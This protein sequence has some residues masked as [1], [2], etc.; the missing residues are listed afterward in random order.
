[1]ARCILLFLLASLVCIA[2][3]HVVDISLD[4]FQGVS[5]RDFFVFKIPLR[6]YISDANL[7][8]LEV[9]DSFRT[10]W[11]AE[12]EGSYCKYVWVYWSPDRQALVELLVVDAESKMERISYK[13]ERF[14][15][16]RIDNHAFNAAFYRTKSEF[17]LMERSIMSSGKASEEGIR[18]SVGSA[19]STPGPD[20]HN[21]NESKAVVDGEGG[22]KNV[23]DPASGQIVEFVRPE[24][25]PKFFAIDFDETFYIHDKEAF[26]KN[27]K[28]F[29]KVR[30]MGYI[31]FI[32]TARPFETVMR[33]LGEDFVTKTGY[34]GYPG[35]YLS[36]SVV[37]DVDGSVLHVSKFSREFLAAF[38]D[39]IEKEDL[40]DQCIFYD[41]RKNYALV[42]PKE[43]V[44][45]VLVIDD[46]PYPK[47]ATPEEILEME[48]ISIVTTNA[49]MDIPMV[50][51]GIDFSSRCMGSNYLAEICPITITKVDALKILMERHGERA[52]A[53]GFIGDGLNDMESMGL[54]EIS[55]AV[56]NASPEV[57]RHAKWV[58]PHSYLMSA[59][60]TAMELVYNI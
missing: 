19:D 57:K 49:D 34:D 50:T 60:A 41:T 5:S 2:K 33:T 7:T 52:S 24:K 36:G 39:Y 29:S 44:S 38:L 56:A 14:I 27:I 55:F 17:E 58:L 22:E 20:C 25:P 3:S 32:C 18:A 6:I 26:E 8:I 4:T 9:V 42:D 16:E 31:P 23:Q 40:K 28:A 35:I 13:K 46:I 11:K 51:R 59:F 37:Y 45:R 48:I 12:H 21:G 1:M 30:Q 54:S 47:I 10:L 53:F 15:W 43:V